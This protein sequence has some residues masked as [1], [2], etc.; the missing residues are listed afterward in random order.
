MRDLERI[1]IVV[2]LCLSCCFPLY[3]DWDVQH[4]GFESVTVQQLYSTGAYEFA[5]LLNR[6][7]IYRR[8]VGTD[9]WT[10]VASYA[11]CSTAT[12]YFFT[13]GHCGS[14]I[15][16]DAKIVSYDSGKTWEEYPYYPRIDNLLHSDG[17]LLMTARDTIFYTDDGESWNRAFVGDKFHSTLSKAGSLLFSSFYGG[18]RMSRDNG[19]TWED[20]SGGL[21][22]RTEVGSVVQ[23]NDNALLVTTENGL[24]WSSL[25][26]FH[27]YPK[28][29]YS[30]GEEVLAVR[31]IDRFE[32]L[33]SVVYGFST[34]DFIQKKD[35]VYRY[36]YSDGVVQAT[37]VAVS[38]NY[39]CFDICAFGDELAVASY[40]GVHLLDTTGKWEVA[41]RGF[42]RKPRVKSTYQGKDCLFALSDEGNRF[43]VHRSYNEG[44]TWDSIYAAYDTEQFS[45]RGDTLTLWG[46]PASKDSV[47]CSYD[48]GDTWSV[49][50]KSTSHVLPAL[51]SSAIRPD[52][53]LWSG[54]DRVIGYSMDIVNNGK[55]AVHTTYIS[56]DGGQTYEIATGIL[57]GV[58]EIADNGNGMLL[59]ERYNDL[60]HSTDSG[61]TWRVL[62]SEKPRNMVAYHKNIIFAEIEKPDE[63][64]FVYG[65]SLDLGETWQP[66]LDT[67]WDYF[68]SPLSYRFEYGK[69]TI[70]RDGLIYVRDLSEIGGTAVLSGRETPL[71][72]NRV[73]V[74]PQNR[75][76]EIHCSSAKSSSY[77]VALYTLSGRQIIVKKGTLA[78]GAQ[79]IL[80]D[81][82]NL[83][84]GIYLLKTRVAE[85][86]FVQTLCIP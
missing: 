25:Y 4:V 31:L 59:G 19:V 58:R 33:D 63:W 72:S 61:K 53:V 23:I 62:E 27:W 54:G 73:T 13:M 80:C 12:P 35:L 14:T 47:Y 26:K 57:G 79:R 84:S 67:A 71:S 11:I 5:T 69:A 75:S 9:E 51:D 77:K 46:Y 56:E 60:A 20:I 55:V 50:K 29:L 37:P 18:L 86:S 38:V 64:D 6:E 43:Y 7:G 34:E 36:S 17:R 68:Y 10:Q 16:T 24:Y 82:L 1:W 32:T 3:A 85:K 81:G 30:Q 83:S 28:K 76:I 48:G 41:G 21:P 39:E 52:R 66:L 44:K 42:K 49:V 22:E 2:L 78:A 40:D 65:Y 70:V 15:Y 74:L 45:L 8:A